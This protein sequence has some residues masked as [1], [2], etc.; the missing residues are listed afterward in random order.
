MLTPMDMSKWT[1]KDPEVLTLLEELWV[2]KDCRVGEIILKES[3][4]NWLSNTN[5]SSLKTYVQVTL[6][7][8]SW[9]YL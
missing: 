4:G 6:H 8:L 3:N 9:L 7:R 2:T 1:R 5:F